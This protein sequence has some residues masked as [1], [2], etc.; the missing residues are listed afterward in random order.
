[1]QQCSRTISNFKKM[2]MFFA[3]TDMLYYDVFCTNTFIIYDVA[4]VV[5]NVT[6]NLP[7]F[8]KALDSILVPIFYNLQA[9][10]RT[11]DTSNDR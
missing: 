7:F 6:S 4:N 3:M 11:C 1:M 9:Y 5:Y 2:R 8:Q 10:D